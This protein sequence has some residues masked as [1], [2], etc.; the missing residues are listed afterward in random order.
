MVNTLLSETRRKNS[1][2]SDNLNQVVSTLQ[3][4]VDRLN[5]ARQITENIEDLTKK[6][7]D[8]IFHEFLIPQGAKQGLETQQY[9]QKY[10]EILEMVSLI[11]KS[12][13]WSLAG[14][15]KE[16]LDDYLLIDFSESLTALDHSPVWY[17]KALGYVKSNHGLTG[18]AA[19]K[20]NSYIDYIIKALN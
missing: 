17:V 7:S 6:A 13:A 3:E 12:L 9:K 19:Q 11:L 20:I 14:G 10:G 4:K 16:L 1:I 5:A 15:G 8:L 2:G 18:K